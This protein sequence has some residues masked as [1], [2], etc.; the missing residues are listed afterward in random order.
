MAD[1]NDINAA[2]SVK[3]IGSDPT[4]VETFPAKVSPNQNL[5][6]DDT[7]NNGGVHG[8]LSVSTTPIEAKVG[9]SVLSNR[10]NLTIF[11]NSNSGRTLY[12]G[13]SNTV[14][15]SNGTPLH[16]DQLLILR[17]GPNTHVWIVFDQGT[18][19]VRVTESA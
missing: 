19:N 17:V 3:I 1:I 4:G 13:Y 11:N 7:S 14:S 6:V 5:G 12:W 18:N 8:A 15:A 16:R 9:G 2:Q 10:K